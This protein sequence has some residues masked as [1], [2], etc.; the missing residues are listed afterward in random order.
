M[1][2]SRNCHTALDGQAASTTD[3]EWFRKLESEVGQARQQLADKEE[4]LARLKDVLER[5]TQPVS[6]AEQPAEDARP[7]LHQADA[8]STTHEEWVRRL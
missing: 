7:K 8:S 1:Q 6:A 4:Q 5:N 2:F 3:Q